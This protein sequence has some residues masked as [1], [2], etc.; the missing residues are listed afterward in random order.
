LNTESYS[1][2][3]IIGDTNFPCLDKNNG[4]IQFSEMLN[5][6]NVYHCDDLVSS[7]IKT[8]YVN[9]ALGHASCIDHFFASLE[10]K[11]D[12]RDIFVTDFGANNSDHL[13]LCGVLNIGSSLFNKCHSVAST[14]PM[15]SVSVRWDRADLKHYYEASRYHL[16]AFAFDYSV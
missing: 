10:L 3:L 5:T 2:I 12:W 14:M 15:K 1:D 7:V 13:P 9:T 8:T 4:F 11:K 16:S 6:F